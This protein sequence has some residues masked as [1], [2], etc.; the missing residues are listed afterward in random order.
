MGQCMELMGPSGFG[1]LIHDSHGSWLVGFLGY[2]WYT[3]NVSV[4]LNVICKDIE[5][6]WNIDYRMI[7]CE[8]DSCWFKPNWSTQC[9]LSSDDNYH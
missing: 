5:L 1:I 7:E 8:L 6:A 4:V 2:C 3:T 9:W